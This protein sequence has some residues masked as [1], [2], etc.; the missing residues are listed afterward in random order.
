MDFNAPDSQNVCQEFLVE[1][2]RPQRHNFLKIS[3]EILRIS[4]DRHRVFIPATPLRN[5]KL[6][7]PRPWFFRI[8][9]YLVGDLKVWTYF[10]D[11]LTY[12]WTVNVRLR[13]AYVHIY[14]Y[15]CIL[16][17]IYIYDC[18]CIYVYIYIIHI[19]YTSYNL[20]ILFHIAKLCWATAHTFYFKGNGAPLNV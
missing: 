6:R 1:K 7:G 18:V 3:W 14:I 19:T 20:H 5:E 17:Y 2:S 16:I 10:R 15:I 13:Y 4:L 12:V 11:F 9:Q 8:S